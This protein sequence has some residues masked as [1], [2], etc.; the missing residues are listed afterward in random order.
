MHD[1]AQNSEINIVRNVEV[2]T[3]NGID[4]KNADFIF[5]P[6]ELGPVIQFHYQILYTYNKPIEKEESEDDEK[7]EK[8]F[9]ILDKEGEL[10]KLSFDD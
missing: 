7:K 3:F 1:I 10:K 2:N 4:L 8:L 5:H 9:F 6:D